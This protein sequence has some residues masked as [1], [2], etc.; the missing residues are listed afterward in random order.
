MTRGQHVHPVDDAV[1]D[2]H[3]VREGLLEDFHADDG[4]VCEQ[5][6]GILDLY[7]AAV[8]VVAHVRLIQKTTA[9]LERLPPGGCTRHSQR[10]FR[11]AGYSFKPLVGSDPG[12]A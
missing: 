4:V 9:H 10:L 7:D 5:E 1:I 12:A 8:S 6:A 11:D 3:L 2:F